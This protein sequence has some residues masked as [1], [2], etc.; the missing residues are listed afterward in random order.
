MYH[1][2]PRRITPPIKRPMYLYLL[3]VHCM[4]V[5]YQLPLVATDQATA[6]SRATDRY[7]QADRI[8]TQRL[9]RIA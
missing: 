7:L 8:T 9:C 4:G 6:A 2:K 5:V 3:T 1:I